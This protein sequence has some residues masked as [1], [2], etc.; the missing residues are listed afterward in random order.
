MESRES[1]QKRNPSRLYDC[2]CRGF[3]LL[4]FA[5]RHF[6]FAVRADQLR[7]SGCC[8]KATA[9][10]QGIQYFVHWLC[11]KV[12]SPAKNR[13]YPSWL[14]QVALTKLGGPPRH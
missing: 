6:I 13:C 3:L 2:L 10:R 8:L 4:Q 9:G 7:F 12:A 14:P 11:L 5:G 1:D